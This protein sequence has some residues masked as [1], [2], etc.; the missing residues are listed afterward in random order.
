MKIAY[1]LNSIKGFGGI[2]RVT[3]V[4]ANSLAEISGNSVYI[5]VTDHQNDFQCELLSPKVTLIDL[6]IRYYED[7]W[8][9]TWKSRVS[10]FKKR[11][12]HKAALKNVLHELQ[13]DVVIAVGQSEKFFC[14]K[15]LRLKSKPIYIREIHFATNYREKLSK[16]LASK[17]SGKIQSFL[18]FGLFCRIQYDMIVCLTPEDL[19]ENWKGRKNVVN[20]PNP[21][22]LVSN[23]IL[24]K[25]VEQIREIKKIVAV[26]RLSYPK[27]FQSLIRSFKLISDRY[28]EWKL[29]IYGEGSDRVLLEQLI[30][31][32]TLQKQ[33]FLMG[34]NDNLGRVLDCAS[35]LVLSSESEG[36][37]LVLLE[38]MDH[39]LP[40]IAY[41]CQFGPS[42]IITQDIDGFLVEQNNEVF[43]ADRMQ[44]LMNDAGL[45]RRM[46]INAKDKASA[47]MPQSLAKRWMDL[48]NLVRR[49]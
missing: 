8:H 36:F 35:F 19:K 12:R 48:F 46:G 22:T 40:V 11:F 7:D 5:L 2:Q 24:G 14:T 39:W 6:N 10:Q 1:C 16:S 17:I 21:L 25:T 15:N 37:P 13:P 43:L 32:L 34:G 45:R 31:Q 41:D 44:Y 38:A 29:E 23:D 33:V 4:K 3:I 42:H 20:M 18:D 47:F 28:P 30:I 27:N 26:G 9:K 49:N